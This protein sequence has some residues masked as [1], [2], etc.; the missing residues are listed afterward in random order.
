MSSAMRRILLCLFVLLLA[1]STAEAQLRSTALVSPE[2][3]RQLGLER[4]WFTQL[5]LDR[6]R[7]RMGGLHMHVS[8]TEAHTIFQITDGGKRYVFSQHDRD[9]FGQAVG[10]DGAKKRA[11]DK[12]AEIKKA[13]E[14]AGKPDAQPPAAEI[15]SPPVE[16]HVVP[17][18]T[19]YAT[20]E[21]GLLH[22]IDGET[23]RTL[24]T[25]NVG[26]PRFPMTAAGANDKFVGVCNGSTLYVMLASDGSLVW[27]RPA[28]SSPGAGPALSTDL[29]FVPM[30]TGQIE[31]FLLED[32]KRPVKIYQSFGRAMVQPVVSANSVAWPTDKGQLYVGMANDFGVRFRME[33]SD[34]ITS[35][36]AFLA[37]DKIFVTS[38]DGYIYCVERIAG[39]H[40]VAVH[41]RRADQPLARRPGRPRVRHYG[42]RQFVRDRHQHSGGAV[43]HAQHSQLR[44]GQRPAAVL[45][46]HA[47]RSG[48]FSTAPA[49]ARWERSLRDSSM[50][51]SSI[52][53]PTGSSWP[54]RRGW[55]SVSA[56]APNPGRPCITSWKRRRKTPNPP[57]PT[58]RRP[59]RK[60]N[61]CPSRT[62]IRSA[63]TRPIPSP[64]RPRPSPPRRAIPSTRR[65]IACVHSSGD[66]RAACRYE[67]EMDI[68]YALEPKLSA[69]DFVELLVRSTLAERRPVG[70]LETIRGM[71]QHAD[72]I[73]TAREEVRLVGVSRA[74]TD[75]HFC[76][77]LSDLAVDAAYQRRGIGRELIRQTHVAAGLKTTLIL[78]AAP[79]ARSYYPY[80]GMQPHDSCW[81][82]PRQAGP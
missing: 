79:A 43:G 2:S 47:R 38:L 70:D 50:C 46:R 56:R 7:G 59:N 62:A 13:L 36:P 14:V 44:I 42:S 63:A 18:I 5:H 6:S 76:T 3:A 4:M 30:V 64:H 9:A 20:S 71:L 49:A 77:Y 35:S 37:P 72:L 65:A 33:A 75:F 34:A 22:A 41:H 17:K 51:P 78:L 68:T 19:F 27:T 10:V 74:I 52:R 73:L 29:I 55:C 12:Q 61:R 54:A 8:S 60:P 82:L 24:W 26:N 66:K 40:G 80:I 16:T 81:V 48:R 39:Q 15:Q 23:G 57:R 31:S 21:R 69:E 58:R 45:L 11:E 28:I 53:R 1:S 32:P 67:G 25:T